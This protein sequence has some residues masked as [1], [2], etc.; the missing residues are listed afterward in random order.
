MKSKSLKP[1]STRPDDTLYLGTQNLNRVDARV[2]EFDYNSNSL[3]YLAKL[4][5]MDIPVLELPNGKSV[6]ACWRKAKHVIN[7]KQTY[8]C[9]PNLG[10]NIRLN[11]LV[12]IRPKGPLCGY[13][14]KMLKQRT[15]KSLEFLTKCQGLLIGT[16][17]ETNFIYLLA[18]PYLRHARGMVM[19]YRTPSLGA[20]RLILQQILHCRNNFP[21]ERLK[22][23]G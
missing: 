14:S 1:S 13:V 15:D 3:G 5:Q 19:C 10:S 11:P 17:Y 21:W 6:P 22:A 16:A 23:I 9:D 8:G 7:R 4:S 18:G 12:R 2:E 20:T